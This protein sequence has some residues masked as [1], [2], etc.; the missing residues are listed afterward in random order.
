MADN[1]KISW[2]HATWQ[3]TH[4]CE[5]IATGCRGCYAIRDVHRM[6]HNPSLKISEPRKGLVH[7]LLAPHPDSATKFKPS[8]DWT[9]VVR[10]APENLS[11]PLRWKKGRRIFVNSNSDLFHKDVPFEFIAAVWG[12]I[13]A[14]PQHRFM[15]LTK[16]IDRAREFFEWFYRDYEAIWRAHVALIRYLP[17]SDFD[18]EWVMDED[19]PRKPGDVATYATLESV[20][21][22][23]PLPNV[24]LYVSGSTQADVDANV[25]VLLDCPAAFRGLSLEPQVERVDLRSVPQKCPSCGEWAMRSEM[26]DDESYWDRDHC[27]ACGVT[28]MTEPAL[29]AHADEDRPFPALDIILQGGESGPNARPFDIAWARYTRDQ[30]RAAGVMYHLKQ[31]GARPYQLVEDFTD[32]G[33]CQRCGGNGE[34]VTCPDDMCYGQ[35]E[36]IHG[37]GYSTCPECGGSGEVDRLMREPLKLNHRDGADPAEW[38]EDLQGCRDLPGQEV[39]RA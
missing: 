24:E 18:P 38:P 33:T 35:E 16:R 4:G 17:D 20:D 2:A 37:D 7:K 31:L 8:L 14:C 21:W 11:Q 28:W 15:V 22:D 27:R 23:S 25:P 12:V 30:C 29:D 26:A 34:I 13:A 32:D 36:C 5:K 9:G 19:E 1:P 39:S 10:T 6:A 3:V